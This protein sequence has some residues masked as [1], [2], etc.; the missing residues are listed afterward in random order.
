ME[1][2]PRYRIFIPKKNGEDVEF[3]TLTK[4]LFNLL[5]ENCLNGNK[6]YWR[7]RGKRV[8]VVGRAS[9]KKPRK[10]REI[11]WVKVNRS[12]SDKLNIDF[13]TLADLILA[14]KVRHKFDRWHNKMVHYNDLLREIEKGE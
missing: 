6:Q 14:D 11:I 4:D 10:K 5:V 1:V 13:S 9:P 3:H 8:T 7:D 12:L 2:K